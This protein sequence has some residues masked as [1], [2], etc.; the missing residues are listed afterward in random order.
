VEVLATERA[1]DAVRRV[2]ATG[3]EDLVLVLG[4]GCC[5]STAPYLY[6]RYLPGADAVR[7]GEVAGVPVFAPAFLD[8]LYPG[9][10]GLVLDVEEGVLSDSFS[11]ESEQ[12]CR[13]VLRLPEPHPAPG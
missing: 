7:V 1:A 2:A 10:D 5:D 11:L 12:G 9:R 4:T 8:R 3:R 6:D 13:F